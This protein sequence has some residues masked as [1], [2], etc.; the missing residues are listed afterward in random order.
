[1]LQ[2]V[3]IK[4]DGTPGRAPKGTSVLDAAIEYGFCIPLLC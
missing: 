4:I 1:M 3:T 2:N